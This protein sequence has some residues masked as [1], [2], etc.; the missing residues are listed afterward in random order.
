MKPS[1][2]IIVFARAPRLG[3]VKTRL[4]PALGEQG[5][6]DLYRAMLRH[7][8]WTAHQCSPDELILACTP[9]AE[10]A[11]LR[12]MGHVVGANLRAQCGGELGARMHHALCTA[13]ERHEIALLIGS[14]CPSL[15]CADLNNARDLLVAAT[16]TAPGNATGGSAEL[17]FIPAT[18]GGY[19][20]VG[21]TEPCAEIFR[22]MPWGGS[23][24]MKMTRQRL[25][26][27]GRKWR[28]LPAHSDIDR[29]Q[30]LVML[31]EGFLR[32]GTSAPK[33]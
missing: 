20:L 2:A 24:V 15:R 13:L 30:D 10:D 32:E 21:A 17:V 28:E 33:F 12:A 18:D 11:G 23:E 19:V 8:L 9:D 6:L 16:D 29:P 3:H 27:N 22:E 5:A 1:T 4:V 26:C 25:R 31:E 14:D 7:A